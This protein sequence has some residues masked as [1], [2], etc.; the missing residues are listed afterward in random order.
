M[1]DLYRHYGNHSLWEKYEVSKCP[2]IE[3]TEIW[4]ADDQ[5]PDQ[6]HS[7]QRHPP[8]AV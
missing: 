1:Q 3:V 2:V 8:V 6:L 4:V 7:H 5:G